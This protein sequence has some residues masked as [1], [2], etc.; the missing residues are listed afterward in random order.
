MKVAG[1]NLASR[2]TQRMK[3]ASGTSLAS[4]MMRLTPAARLT[5]RESRNTSSHRKSE[6]QTMAGTLL[7]PLKTGKKYESALKSMTP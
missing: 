2:G 7:P 1:S 5:P 4:V 6:A 3:S